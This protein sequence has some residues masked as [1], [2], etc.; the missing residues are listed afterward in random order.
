MFCI[1]EGIFA[2]E[3][4][5][6]SCRLIGDVID[7]VHPFA[8]G[9]DTKIEGAYVMKYQ[10]YYYCLYSSFTRSYEVR[11]SWSK[12]MEGPWETKYDRLIMTPKDGIEIIS[13]S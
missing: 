11:V 2:Y 1:P 9:W 5:F 12:A 10:D 8:D 3:I 13:L 7:M 4:E 6:P